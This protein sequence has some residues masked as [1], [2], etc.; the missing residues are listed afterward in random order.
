MVFLLLFVCF[1]EKMKCLLCK[2]TYIEFYN[3]DRNNRFSE[4][5]F[6]RKIYYFTQK[7]CLRCDELIPNS[8]NKQ[9]HDFFNTLW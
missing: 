9:I 5:L 3:I 8:K 4:N 6:G 7:K 2:E 1:F